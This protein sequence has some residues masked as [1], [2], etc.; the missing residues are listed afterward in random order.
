MSK[1]K[2]RFAIVKWILLGTVCLLFV[3]YVAFNLA[4]AF[5]LSSA[6]N[7]MAEDESLFD[8]SHSSVQIVGE[9]DD[10]TAK[11]NFRFVN[12][13]L[14]LQIPDGTEIDQHD[15]AWDRV[16]CCFTFPLAENFPELPEPIFEEREQITQELNFSNLS[17]QNR[18][19]PSG[20]KVYDEHI[21]ENPYTQFVCSHPDTRRLWVYYGYR[22]P[23][24]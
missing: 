18:E 20:I 5:T 15:N 1:Q 11:S 8:L 9:F 17:L 23:T 22:P 14:K 7:V 12:G 13:G 16:V 6:L 10:E 4:A 21:A 19:I 2:N 24:D 3:G